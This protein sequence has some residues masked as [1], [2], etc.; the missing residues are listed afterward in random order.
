MTD[1]E[2]RLECVASTVSSSRRSSRS[3]SSIAA[4]PAR[5][6]AEKAQ[7]RAE[8]AKKEIE[9]QVEKACIEARLNALKQEYEAEA[10]SAEGEVFEAL[11][12]S[13]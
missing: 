3:T 1:L 10:A 11:V 5:A 6:K 8:Y 12:K 2:A 4:V 13:E 7:R 9:M